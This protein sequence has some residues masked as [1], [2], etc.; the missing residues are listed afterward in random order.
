M[1]QQSK[2]AYLAGFVDG[3]GSFSITKGLSGRKRDGSKYVTFKLSLS[4]CNTN[5]D[6]MTWIAKTFGG[7]VL[8][9]SNAN[10][11]PKYKTRYSWTLSSFKDIERVT[12]SILPYLIVKRQQAILTLEF[13]RTANPKIGEWLSPEVQ[14]KRDEIRREMMRLNGIFSCTPSEPVETSTQGSSIE[15]EDTVRA[16]ERSEESSRNACSAPILA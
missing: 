14:Q 8:T 11:N 7:K 12:I 1:T 3:E 6:V 4:V 15:D 2:F 13:C 5:R 9:G 16:S 10:R